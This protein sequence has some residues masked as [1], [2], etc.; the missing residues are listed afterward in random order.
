MSTV[1]ETVKKTF[2]R[3]NK[4]K[5]TIALAGIMA[6]TPGTNAQN[7]TQADVNKKNNV[8]LMQKGTPQVIDSLIT[9]QKVLS[10][11]SGF[12]LN[13]KELKGRCVMS[14]VYFGCTT[15]SFMVVNTKTGEGICV[16]DGHGLGRYAV[17][18]YKKQEAPQRKGRFDLPA[19][20]LS[21]DYQL[22]EY[23]RSFDEIELPPSIGK[24]FK[25]QYFAES[26]IWIGLNEKGNEFS[27]SNFYSNLMEDNQKGTYNMKKIIAEQKMVQKTVMDLANNR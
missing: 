21:G 22:E 5:K 27:K 10:V 9:D 13:P 6:V 3:L 8:E 14:D 19:F 4:Y 24:Y 11:A 15:Q 25:P 12:G 2:E 26:A 20:S 1:S 16:S 7:T 23:V 18:R 17:S